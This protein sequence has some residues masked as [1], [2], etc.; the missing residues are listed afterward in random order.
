MLYVLLCM[1]VVA[2]LVSV[3]TSY[4]ILGD[5][6]NDTTTLYVLSLIGRDRTREFSHTDML[7]FFATPW[8]P[9]LNTYLIYKTIRDNPELSA[10]IAYVAHSVQRL[11]ARF[12]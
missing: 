7:Y 2:Y 1:L 8:I 6:R 12:I 11:L 4:Q 9:V 5:S 10:Q 3:I